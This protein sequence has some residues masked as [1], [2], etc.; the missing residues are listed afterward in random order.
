MDKTP[1]W[2]C[3]CGAIPCYTHPPTQYVQQI[4]NEL[5]HRYER[6]MDEVRHLRDM[7]SRA[8]DGI[9]ELHKKIR[10]LTNLSNHHEWVANKYKTQYEKVVAEMQLC[11]GAMKADDERLRNA[12][13]R[14]FGEVTFGCDAAER[15]ADEIEELRYEL[16]RVT[17]KLCGGTG[18]KVVGEHETLT[19]EWVTDYASCDHQE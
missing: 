9:E 10:R 15:M 17:C 14:V 2:D 4:V 11:K 16:K 18:K 19:N 5:Q 1:N 6:A 7:N 3:R 12:E 13:H 8:N